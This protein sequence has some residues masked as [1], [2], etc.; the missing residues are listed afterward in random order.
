MDWHGMSWIGMECHGLARNVMNW[1]GLSRIGMECHGLAWN[2]MEYI[3]K[4]NSHNYLF[5]LPEV[6][7]TFKSS[8]VNK[9]PSIHCKVSFSD[10]K[11]AFCTF[12]GKSQNL[13]SEVQVT[14]YYDNL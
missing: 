7:T 3:L 9:C 8:H 10:G 1:H 11:V 2:V 6:C 13:S 4:L 12:V 5:S 14:K